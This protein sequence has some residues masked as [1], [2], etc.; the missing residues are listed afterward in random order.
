VINFIRFFGGPIHMMM[1]RYRFVEEDLTIGTPET[2]HVVAQTRRNFKLWNR[3]DASRHSA[4][5]SDTVQRYRDLVASHSHDLMFPGLASLLEAAGDGHCD[6]CLYRDSYGAE[7][8]H[9]FGG[10]QLCDDCKASWLAYLESFPERA[11]KVFPEILMVKPEP[12]M[13]N[14][15]VDRKVRGIG[16]DSVDINIAVG[17]VLLA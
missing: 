5:A 4:C 15:V 7:T 3:V 9:C 1:R 11:A 17:V 2:T 8:T 13:N 16:G 14:V 6:H 10:V 12:K